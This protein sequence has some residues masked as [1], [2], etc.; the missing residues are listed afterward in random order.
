L[1]AGR[2]LAGRRLAA[3]A[4]LVAAVAA[5]GCGTAAGSPGSSGASGAGSETKVVNLVAYSTPQQV[6]EHL[7]PAFQATPAGKGVKFTQSY[8]AS[9]AQERAVA[10][11]QPADVVEFSLGADMAKLVKAGLVAPGWASNPYHGFV[12][13]SVA[14]LVVRKGNP[15]HRKLP[16]DYKM[17]S[18]RH[19]C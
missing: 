1:I 13:D 10:A 11:G 5:A 6:Y 12:T 19:T 14:V 9:G 2:R 17:K 15:K 16:A 7:I 8:G 3:G 18:T 4:A